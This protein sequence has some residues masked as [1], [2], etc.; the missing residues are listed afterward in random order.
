M[1]HATFP[2][3]PV[4]QGDGCL[5]GSL[6]RSTWFRC[7]QCGMVFRRARRAR[8]PRTAAPKALGGAS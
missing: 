2:P 8:G 7:R 6:G 3:C 1:P 4:C 5:L